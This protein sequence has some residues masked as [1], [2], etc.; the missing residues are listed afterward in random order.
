MSEKI[1]AAIFSALG[2]VSGL[3]AADVYAGSGA[4]GLEA[5]SRGATQVTFIDNLKASLVYLRD[6]VRLLELDKN[7][8]RLFD[9]TVSNWC[10]QEERQFNL[11]FVDPPYAAPDPAILPALKERLL[12][13]GILVLSWPGKTDMPAI[14]GL[15]RVKQKS[16]GDAQ[17]GYYRRTDL[18]S[19]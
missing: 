1:R 11:L 3:T 8:Y 16:Y 17:V 15:D 5:I 12:V 18:I 6:N 7:Q 2:D 19:L 10:R 9:K 14:A 4:V 13:G